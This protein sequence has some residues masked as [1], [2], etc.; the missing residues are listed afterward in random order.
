[1]W[2]R[3]VRIVKLS[4]ILAHLLEC[5]LSASNKHEVFFHGA[6]PVKASRQTVKS[7][8]TAFLRNEKFEG[9]SPRWFEPDHWG[10]SLVPVGTGGRGGAWFLRCDG[11]DIVLRHYYR[12]GLAAHLSKRRYIFTGFERSRSF[13]EFRILSQL[14][15]LNLPVPEPVGAL[16]ER[17]GTFRYQAAILVRRIPGAVAMLEHDSIADDLIWRQV[18]ETIAR[19]HAEGLDHVDLNCDNILVSANDVYL[20]DFDRCKLRGVR[21][22]SGMA[23]WQKRNLNRLKRSLEKRLDDLPEGTLALRWQVLLSGYEQSLSAS[24]KG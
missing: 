14:L 4:R 6:V 13:R 16:A 5:V 23:G 24:K 1:M 18:G 2:S 20:I 12:G 19:F 10:A 17:V 15:K 8:E 21:S 22:D 11:E 7:G 3:A 9:L